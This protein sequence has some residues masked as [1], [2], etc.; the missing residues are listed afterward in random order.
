MKSRLKEIYAMLG[1]V[2]NDPRSFGL[3][4]R[5]PKSLEDALTKLRQELIE[6]LRE[7]TPEEEFLETELSQDADCHVVRRPRPA[8]PIRKTGT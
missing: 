6:E 4:E 1:R 5:I 8:F 2:L 7:E 3:N